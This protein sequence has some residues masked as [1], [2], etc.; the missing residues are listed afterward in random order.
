MKNQLVN[1][2][3]I[4]GSALI[5]SLIAAPVMAEESDEDKMTLRERIQQ[6]DVDGDGQLNEEERTALREARRA[7]V[8]EKF[9]ADGDGEL[10]ETERQ[11]KREA[12]RARIVNKFDADGDGELNDE[13]KQAAR[14]A[15]S[16]MKEKRQQFRDNQDDSV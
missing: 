9:D 7:Y 15:W 16:K 1:K 5:F 12:K 2:S 13:E 6:Y 4:L 14:E 11:A 8:L 3:S 10:N